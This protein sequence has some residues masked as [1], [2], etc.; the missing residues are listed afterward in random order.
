MVLLTLYL[1]QSSKDKIC[2]IHNYITFLA[3]LSIL[4]NSPR[5]PTGTLCY[6]NRENYNKAITFIVFSFS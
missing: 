5:A 6:N 4:G 2:I 1:Y 3:C